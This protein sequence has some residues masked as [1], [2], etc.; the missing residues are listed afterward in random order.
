MTPHDQDRKDYLI[1]AVVA[2]IEETKGFAE[3]VFYDGTECDGY[4][5]I[6][7]IKAEWDHVFCPTETQDETE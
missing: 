3:T 7:D 2:Y 4:C 6:D 5:L 1:R